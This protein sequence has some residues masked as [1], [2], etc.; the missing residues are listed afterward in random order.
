M[1]MQKILALI[2]SILMAITSF[3]PA[4]SGKELITVD[5]FLAQTYIEFGMPDDMGLVSAED[6]AKCGTYLNYDVCY[7]VL[8]DV[9]SGCFSETATFGWAKI[10]KIEALKA[11]VDA[12]EAWAN[13]TFGE[14][15]AEQITPEEVNFSGDFEPVLAQSEF[16]DG[17]GNVLQSTPQANK[18]SGTQ[19]NLDI[20]GLLQKLDVDFSI[21]SFDF[22]LKVTD[23]GF[24]LNIETD[25]GNNA[26]IKKSYNVTD[27]SI[28]THFDGNLATKDIRSMYIRADYNLL[29][30]TILSGSYAATVAEKIPDG[31]DSIGFINAAKQGLLT[32]VQGSG[33]KIN[34]FSISI[35]I[36]NV[37]SVTIKL[38]VSI[39]INIYGKIEISITSN[40]VKGIE[41]INNKVRII[42][43]TEYGTQSYLVAADVEFIVG[44]TLS[45]NVL[46]YCVADFCVNGGVGATANI[47][48]QTE[49]NVFI[50]QMP[51]DFALELPIPNFDKDTI[52]VCGA[53]HIYGILNFGVGNNSPLLKLLGLTKTWVIYDKSNNTIYDLHLEND[54]DG[55]CI[56]VDEC[57]RART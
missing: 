48:A 1:T 3:V 38:D 29:D 6:I 44:L 26:H 14:P 50:L 40:N 39:S 28:S 16:I 27:L 36:P 19:K 13:K 45:L 57:T 52:M 8:F 49:S 46:N 33:N 7:S 18:S 37:P 51:M 23:S 4:L 53:I 35:P 10:G 24:D 5:D 47:Y 32:L 55:N 30:S 34:V 56:V 41:I 22:G 2:L 9:S 12:K 11:I 43:E 15:V 20:E 54:A 21:G 31:M 17:N 25:I 42:N